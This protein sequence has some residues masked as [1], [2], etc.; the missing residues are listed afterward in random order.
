MRS[1]NVI[2]AQI[3]SQAAPFPS[4]YA[5]KDWAQAG[6]KKPSIVRPKLATLAASLVRYKPGSL[7]GAD[8][9]EVDGRLR[10]VLRL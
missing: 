1:D 6:L 3:T 7:T 4:D 8:L 5:L 2:V 9:A 10:R